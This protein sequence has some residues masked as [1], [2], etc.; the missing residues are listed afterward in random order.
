LFYAVKDEKHENDGIEIEAFVDESS[1]VFFNM[2][3][4]MLF[5]GENEALKCLLKIFMAR[6]ILLPFILLVNKLQWPFS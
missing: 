1:I 4:E 2:M 3:D 5:Y 6:E